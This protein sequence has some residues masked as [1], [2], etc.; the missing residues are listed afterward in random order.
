[1]YILLSAAGVEYKI[2]T[3]RLHYMRKCVSHNAYALRVTRNTII[4]EPKIGTAMM[5]WPQQYILKRCFF[6]VCVIILIL[7]TWWQQKHNYF[8]IP[9]LIVVFCLNR[10]ELW[11][12]PVAQNRRRFR[13]SN[14]YIAPINHIRAWWTK[15]RPRARSVMIDADRHIR[16]S[17]AW[18]T[19]CYIIY[20]SCS[21]ALRLLAS[22]RVYIFKLW[23]HNAI[24]NYIYLRAGSIDARRGNRYAVVTRGETIQFNVLGWARSIRCEVYLTAVRVYQM[25]CVHMENIWRAQIY[26]LLYQQRNHTKKY[27]KII[28]TYLDCI[29]IYITEENALQLTLGYYMRRIN[30]PHTCA[31]ESS[32]A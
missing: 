15:A 2:A 30:N 24:V 28:Y 26:K 5:S 32:S 10:V 21:G 3:N 29:Y 11:L 9:K 23:G 1:M 16:E 20:A 25:C 12:K 27:N 7:I 8:V 19:R 14:S 22:A 4:Y 17:D 18:K 31:E 13:F 6:Q